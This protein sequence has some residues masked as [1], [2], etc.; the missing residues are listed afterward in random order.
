MKVSSLLV[1]S[2]V[3][4]LI[5]L[6]KPTSS[7]FTVY[8]NLSPSSTNDYLVTAAT[9]NYTLDSLLH[10]VSSTSVI[11]G[12]AIVNSTTGKVHSLVQ[13]RRV[14]GFSADIGLLTATPGLDYYEMVTYTLRTQVYISR[15]FGFEQEGVLVDKTEFKCLK[16][17]GDQKECDETLR[18]VGIVDG[19][20]LLSSVRQTSYSPL[21]GIRKMRLKTT[22]HSLYAWAT[23]NTP[24]TVFILMVTQSALLF[25]SRWTA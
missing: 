8:H 1:S 21:P 17:G 22:T 14:T 19:Y 24:L 16:L 13:Q 20:C 9:N 6:C 12:G 10:D 7:T 5:Y 2:L 4:S 18:C 3:G 11:H 25:V 23:N 15:H